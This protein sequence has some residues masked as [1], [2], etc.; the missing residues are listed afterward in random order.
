M[1]MKQIDLVPFPA[2]GP[3]CNTHGSIR[4]HLIPSNM[5][6]QQES[7]LQTSG[8]AYRTCPSAGSKSERHQK[9]AWVLN[10]HP[11]PEASN[12]THKTCNADMHRAS[13]T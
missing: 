11:C 1:R 9:C 6:A 13:I 8:S 7:F 2:R 4:H 12:S 10:T 3:I 5:F